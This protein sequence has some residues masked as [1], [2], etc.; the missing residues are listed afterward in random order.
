MEL[1]PEAAG[2]SSASSGKVLEWRCS[3]SRTKRRLF[4]GKSQ[5]GVNAHTVFDDAMEDD[6]LRPKR[7]RRSSPLNERSELWLAYQRLWPKLLIGACGI[8]LAITALTG[9]LKHWVLVEAFGVAC[10]VLDTVLD[11]L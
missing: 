11:D 2:T 10:L 5:R 8:S 9:E 4:E 3:F 6:R 7:T 1:H